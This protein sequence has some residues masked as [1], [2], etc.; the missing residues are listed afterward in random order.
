MC[1]P[2]SM[3][4]GVMSVMGSL[5]KGQAAKKAA[6]N[7]FENASRLTIARR[8]AYEQ[9]VEFQKKGAAWQKEVYDYTAAS[10]QKSLTGQYSALLD[11]LN[12]QRDQTFEQANR[13]AATADQATAQMRAA[14][15]GQAVG[16]SVRLAQQAYEVAALRQK[17]TLF[18]NMDAQ[19][20][21]GE[22]EML[23]LQSQAQTRLN[24][25]MP[26]PMRPIDPATPVAHVH[27]PSM[28]P[29]LI[30]GASGII[31][32]AAHYQSVSPTSAP[33]VGAEIGPVYGAGG[34]NTM[35]PNAFTPPPIGTG[36]VLQ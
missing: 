7:Q 11:R 4:M 23:A 6:K 36:T 33:P 20:R 30:E 16:N 35:A 28:T 22:R 32:A 1:E 27:N 10:L 14:S 9:A 25:A 19:I 29:Y 26:A 13:Y 21:Q 34:Y 24:Q 15:S 8:D 3:A 5:S 17:Q 2:V 18:K 12:Q 31:G